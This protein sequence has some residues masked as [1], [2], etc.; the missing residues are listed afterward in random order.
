VDLAEYPNVARW[1]GAI[2]AR[3]AVVRG[4]AVPKK[5]TESAAL[6]PAAREVLFG[7]TQY[8]RR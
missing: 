2:A 4:L 3:P 6:D 7:K 8:E 1:Q 5:P